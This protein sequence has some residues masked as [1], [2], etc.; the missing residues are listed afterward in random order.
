M[1]EMQTFTLLAAFSWL[2]ASPAAIPEP[3]ARGPDPVVYW[4][5]VPAE[6]PEGFVVVIDPGHDPQEPGALSYSGIREVRFNDRLAARVAG[7]LAHL[8][9]VHPVVSRR[10]HQPLPLE[11]RV[12]RI[13]SLEPDLVVSLHHDSVKPQFITYRPAHGTDDGEP[14]ELPSCGRFSGYSLFAQAL[15]PHRKVSQRFARQVADGFRRLGLRRTT[16]HAMHIPGENRRWIDAARGIHAGDYLYL[17]RKLDHPVVL[18][19]SGFLV[20]R[21]EERRL[22]DPEEVEAQAKTLAAAI[23]AVAHDS[24]ASIGF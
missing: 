20:N 14:L 10:S 24:Y 3:D 8:P 21:D 23:A 4:D 6:R 13:A 11:A 12:A 7:H 1:R 22:R 5:R 19:E 9:G 2:V 16:Y 17:L 18:V 15:G